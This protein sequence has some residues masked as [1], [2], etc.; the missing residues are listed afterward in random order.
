MGLVLLQHQRSMLCLFIHAGCSSSSQG[1]LVGLCRR[2]GTMQTM[3]KVAQMHGELQL[4]TTM[5]L[6]CYGSLLLEAAMHPQSSWGPCL[7]AEGK[8]LLLQG[9]AHGPCS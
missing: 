9:R 6:F 3:Q 7:Q 2:G 5:G 1:V 4:K 8:L